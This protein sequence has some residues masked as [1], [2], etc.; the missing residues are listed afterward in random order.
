MSYNN[1][2]FDTTGL[3]DIQFG[4]SLTVDSSIRMDYN[5]HRHLIITFQALTCV[6]APF[7]VVQ[8]YFDIV[9]LDGQKTTRPSGTR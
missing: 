5:P 7:P 2:H 8:A 3:P 6:L 9:N 4:P 1:G